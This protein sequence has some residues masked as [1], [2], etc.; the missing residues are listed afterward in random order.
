MGCFV[1]KAAQMDPGLNHRKD[2]YYPRLYEI[3]CGN[4]NE[5]TAS[6]RCSQH[7]ATRILHERCNGK[8]LNEKYIT[9]YMCFPTDHNPELDKCEKNRS[10]SCAGLVETLKC[11]AAVY[12]MQCRNGAEA[13]RDIVYRRAYYNIYDWDEC[14]DD[15]IY[16]L[17]PEYAS[18][19]FGTAFGV[20]I[21][22]CMLII[23]GMGAILYPRKRTA[24]ADYHQD[25]AINGENP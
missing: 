23:V 15:V 8:T 16:A 21:C 7:L 2:S 3:L 24:A 25:V 19:T 5:I 1:D 20:M 22:V 11:K 6:C 18:K 9:F 17:M 10:D 12:G 4:L 14:Q 13:F